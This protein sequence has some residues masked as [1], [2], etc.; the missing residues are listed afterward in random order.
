MIAKAIVK[1]G[2]TEY[3]FQADEKD[4][5]DSLHIVIALSS[6]RRS[7]NMCNASQEEFY[8]TT[9]KN[10]SEKG[11]FTFVNVKCGKCEA[12]SGLGQYKSGGYFW[13][14]FEKYGKGGQGEQATNEQ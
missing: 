8:F 2:N 10:T 7:C 1:L 14:D 12:R 9:N 3:E 11:T 6:I 5:I 4:P 13:K